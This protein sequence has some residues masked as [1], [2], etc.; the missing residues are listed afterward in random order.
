MSDSTTIESLPAQTGGVSMNIQ[1][2]KPVQPQSMS[3]QS[4][5]MPSQQVGGSTQPNIA[6][7]QPP[8]VMNVS[9]E[10]VKNNTQNIPFAPTQMDTNGLDKAMNGITEL[11]SR[12]IPM[13]TTQITNDAQIKPD[14][15]PNQ[16]T[17]HYI[18]E[19]DTYNTMVQQSKQKEQQQ[20][21]LDL[22]YE[23][24]QLPIL[25]MVLFFIFQLPFVQ[26]KLISYFPSLFLKDERMSM[27]GYIVKTMLFGISFYALMKLINYSSEL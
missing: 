26:K 10:N 11:P 1:E 22:I 20:D 16:N 25:I 27:S 13:N 19:N 5:N 8:I 23:E 2:K 3:T 18:E 4:T 6:P 15:L 7:T 17:K 21:R 14:Y 24:F 12:D 9:N